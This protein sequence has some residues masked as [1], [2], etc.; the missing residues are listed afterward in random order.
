VQGVAVEGLLGTLREQE[1]VVYAGSGWE[2]EV[3][4]GWAADFLIGRWGGR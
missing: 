1:V 3:A 2:Q 4:I